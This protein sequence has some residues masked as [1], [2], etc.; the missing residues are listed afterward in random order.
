MGESGV[1]DWLDGCGGGL[2]LHGGAWMCVFLQFCVLYTDVMDKKQ[3]LL[4]MNGV[5][6]FEVRKRG[7]WASY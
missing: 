1:G 6:V 5:D 2:D 4:W 7:C 3:V